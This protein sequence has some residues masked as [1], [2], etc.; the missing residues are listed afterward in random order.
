MDSVGRVQW[1]KSSYS[2]GNGGACVEVAGLADGGVGV[3]DS[4]D[5][6]GVVLAFTADAWTAFTAGVRAKEFDLG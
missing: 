3:R 5:A 4:K 6:G 2:G 1:R